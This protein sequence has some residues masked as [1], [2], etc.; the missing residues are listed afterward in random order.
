MSMVVVICG[1]R[2]YPI[3]REKYEYKWLNE[4]KEKYDI[5]EVVSGNA[6]GADSW[7]EAWAKF[8]AKVDITIMP[9]N[10]EK[11]EKAA[12]M[13]RNERMRYYLEM[14]KRMRSVD[15]AILAFAGSNGT[16]DMIS[17]AK[18]AN[19]SVFEYKEII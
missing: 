8:I 19:I 4:L 7:G 13:I 11:H 12:G 9:A 3:F 2:N 17:R 1:G 18:L 16:R 5:I 10:W 15:I 6:S 14:C